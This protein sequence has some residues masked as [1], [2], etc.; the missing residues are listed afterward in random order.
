MILRWNWM[1]I[2]TPLAAARK[3]SFWQISVPP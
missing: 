1:P 3:L 2:D